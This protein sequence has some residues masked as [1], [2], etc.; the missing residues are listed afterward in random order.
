MKERSPTRCKQ[1]VGRS[2]WIPRLVAILLLA[3]PI[4][5]LAAEVPAPARAQALTDPVPATDPPRA[6][7]SPDAAASATS[8]DRI[9]AHA[10]LV[11]Q[12]ERALAEGVYRAGLESAAKAL[13]LA[14][15]IGDPLRIGVTQ[16]L[17]A[18][19]LAATNE[20]DEAL[21]EFARARVSLA[22]NPALAA[23]NRLNQA[24]LAAR[25]GRFDEAMAAYQEVADG[26]RA[27]GDDELA[28]RALVNAWRAR[29]EAHPGDLSQPELQKAT[30]ALDAVERPEI[31]ASLAIHLARSLELARETETGRNPAWALAANQLLTRALA[32]ADAVRSAGLRAEALGA[33]G[34]LY[35]SEGHLEEAASLTDRALAQT[36]RTESVTS[37]A[38]VRS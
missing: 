34:A 3:G 7:D 13:E 19:L 37:G 21:A 36:R 23:A 26:A 10:M 4:Q 11:E 15:A 29:V 17:R 32:D 24:N 28:A 2:R 33:L 18:Q 22:G 35:E 6:I 1:A 8:A 9:A 12:I 14:R 30:Q 20:T 16:S 5:G 25:L 27:R 38:R 31:R